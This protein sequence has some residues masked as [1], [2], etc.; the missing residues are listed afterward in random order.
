MPGFR[1]YAILFCLTVTFGLQAALPEH[2][3]PNG[4][5]E[6]LRIGRGRVL[7]VEWHLGGD[8]LLVDTII[9]AW[10]YTPTL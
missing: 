5:E 3:L 4:F 1:F 8:M 6:T 10:L 2:Q 7:D 9:G